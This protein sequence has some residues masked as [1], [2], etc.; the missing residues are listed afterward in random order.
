MA[1]AP[2]T[3]NKEGVSLSVS[4]FINERVQEC[5]FA[6]CPL[7]LH[8]CH[9]LLNKLKVWPTVHSPELTGCLASYPGLLTPAFVA[10][11]TNTG[12]GL[13]KLSHMP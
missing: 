8:N 2:Y 10:C 1:S 4:T 3:F 11:S 5:T 12:E 9:L 6:S 13:V 7:S